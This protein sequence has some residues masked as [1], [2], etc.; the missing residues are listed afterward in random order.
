[1]SWT[2]AGR[3][4]LVDED[5]ADVSR[6]AAGRCGAEAIWAPAAVLPGA[7]VAW[8]APDDRHI[9]AR[10]AVGDTPIDLDYELDEGGHLQAFRTTRW[11]D[12]DGTGRWGW[13]PF[14]GRVLATRTFGSSVVPAS[15][16]VGW[17]PDEADARRRAFFRFRL[18]ALTRGDRDGC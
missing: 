13:H 7:G 8:S 3:V 5:G 1:M 18:T 16:A 11:G 2:L 14:G 6:S 15:G 10:F 12:P 9:R 4:T 17:F